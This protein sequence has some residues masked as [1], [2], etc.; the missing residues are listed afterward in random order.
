MCDRRSVRR[1]VLRSSLLLFPRLT[2]LR[3]GPFGVPTPDVTGRNPTS[4]GP[5][6]VVPPVQIEGFVHSEVSCRL[7]CRDCG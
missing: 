1:W 4:V 2:L 3:A 6:G 7:Y 5:F